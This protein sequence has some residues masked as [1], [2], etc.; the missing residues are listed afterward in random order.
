[1]TRRLLIASIGLTVVVLVVLVV[2]LGLSFADREREDLLAAVERDAVAIAFYI[3]DELDPEATDVGI[4]VQAVADGYEQR[5]GGRVVV[6]D[7]QGISVADSEP[8]P[9]SAAS[10]RDFTTRPEVA[11]ALGGSVSRGTRRS[12]TLGEGFVFVAVPVASGGLVDGA[13]RITYPTAAVDARVRRNWLVLGGLSAVTL[14]TAAVISLVLAA[15]VTRPLRR[16]QSAAVD[17]GEGDLGTRVPIEQGPPEIRDVATTFNRMAAQLQ[18]LVGAQEQFVADAS[19]ELRTPL[20]A[21]RLRLEVL[22]ATERPDPADLDAALAEVGRLAR[23]VESLLTLARADRPGAE[24]AAPVPLRPFLLDRRDAW[25]PLAAES[26]VEVTVEVQGEPAAVTGP[27]RLAQVVDNLLANALEVAP[28]GS[29]VRLAAAAVP[30]GK[31]EVHVV[32]AGPGLTSEERERA[33][34]RF[35]RRPGGRGATGG[36]GIGLAI[37]RKLVTGDGGDVRLDEATG[38]GI[39]AVVRL[40]AG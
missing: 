31:V 13:V 38:G 27:D 6:V 14:A 30:G 7:G 21:L 5:T 9:G 20:T 36:S 3:E 15:S 37:V 22:Q 19:H 10:G 33:F 11:T 18:A 2:P 16:L 35:W 1:M 8:P 25:A 34:D 12:T 40:P 23:L 4:D 39:D 32:D 17:L 29:T 28:E 24:A 26:G